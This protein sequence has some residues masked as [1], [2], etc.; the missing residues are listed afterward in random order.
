M[1]SDLRQWEAFNSLRHKEI[2][3]TLQPLTKLV[4]GPQ[5]CPN[6]QLQDLNQ[7]CIDLPALSLDT[8]QY[9]LEA[10][11]LKSL[12]YPELSL[13]H[14]IIPEPHAVTL[15]WAFPPSQ[16]S[17]MD[18][19]GGICS[20]LSGS[21]GL[22]WV[23]GKPGSG[24]ST[25]I[26]FIADNTNTQ[27]LLTQWSK[28]QE[29][30]LAAHYFTIYGTP[31][32]RSLE[33]LF[34]SLI[35]KILSQEPTL[36]RKVLPQRYKNEK[37][38]EPWKQSELQSVL[39]KLARELVHSRL[40]F[41]IDGLD[42]YAGDH[43][44]ICETLQDLSRSPCVKLCVSSR[45]WNVFE[46]A[47]GGDTDSKLYMQDVTRADIQQYTKTML[48]SHPRWDSLVFEAG[49]DKADSLV[50]QIIDKS[51]G[52]FLWVTLVTRLLRE[53]LTND[54]S[55][56]DLN[57]RLE[58]FPS[59]LE[60]FFRLILDS[61][62][63][64]YRD[65]MARALLFALHAQKPLHI[66]MYM[67]HDREYEE[68]DY[69]LGEPER[70]IATLQQRTSQ[71]ARVFRRVNGWCKGLLERNHDQIEFLHRT[72]YDFLATPEMQQTL[73]EKAKTNNTDFCPLLSLLRASI[74]HTK[75]S[76]WLQPPAFTSYVKAPKAEDPLVALTPFA[77]MVKDM[78]DYARRLESMGGETLLSTTTLLDN[79]DM[80]IGTVEANGEVRDTKTIAIA[81]V[82][83][84]YHVL[85]AGLARYL[86]TKLPSTTYFDRSSFA[87]FICQSPLSVIFERS[88]SSKE[89]F[90]WVAKAIMDSGYSPNDSFLPSEGGRE[91]ECNILSAMCT[92]THYTRIF[93][94]RQ[95]TPWQQ[96][97]EMTTSMVLGNENTS[98]PPKTLS[99][100]MTALEYDAFLLLL[101]Y[102]ANV[103]SLALIKVEGETFTIPIWLNFLLYAVYL[104][105]FSKH[106][107]AYETT[108]DHMLKAAE[109]ETW[110]QNL[111]G[112]DHQHNV[113]Q[114]IK[115]LAGG[116]MVLQTFAKSLSRLT[117]VER[118]K[119]AGGG[120]LVVR[121][122][123][124]SLNKEA[125]ALL[126]P[127]GLNVV[128]VEELRRDYEN[129]IPARGA[130]RG[131][132]VAKF[133]TDDV[134][135][136]K[137]AKRL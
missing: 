109:P 38:Q 20:W 101:G 35:Y 47:L 3:N 121:I 31:I 71:A 65:R 29:V 40:C 82:L 32:Q 25:F 57:R 18:A 77:K 96:L 34:R 53:G 128:M 98:S 28:G 89:A 90:G 13:R 105:F 125:F 23:S 85:G 75:R 21:G 16:G 103:N 81:R 112:A 104:P 69:A 124:E 116:R 94:L 111:R 49:S 134:R 46:N 51:S 6:T 9:V 72:L 5:G 63:P 56:Q 110:S 83:Y 113:P 73:K 118:G 136:W 131:L 79:M 8:R 24:K 44:D 64:F 133:A 45:P 132:S 19:I 27:K 61:V 36:I 37:I 93:S 10:T 50:Q 52:V 106:T 129:M 30:I 17:N 97:V 11:V 108:L 42:E 120:D 12:H 48:R 2:L 74:A 80:S 100:F 68:E 41:F 70:M 102:G 59:E 7:L 66:Q 43:L 84:R 60:P 119:F 107:T 1:Q 76:R 67:F 130:K 54:D 15:H 86:A 39:K 92:I 14:D 114:L 126:E 91:M 135:D 87:L 4:Q 33:G 58:S 26:K 95:G 78:M 22:F 122:L 123:P 115:D 137:I 127:L 117:R 62:D 99:D 55:I 88:P